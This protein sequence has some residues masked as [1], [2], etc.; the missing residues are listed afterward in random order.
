MD[1][2]IK[3]NFLKFSEGNLENEKGKKNLL[4]SEDLEGKTEEDSKFTLEGD[5]TVGEISIGDE[6]GDETVE[7][8]SIGNEDNINLVIE[9]INNDINNVK[10]DKK[11]IN[12]KSDNENDSAIGNLS[13][14]TENTELTKI[15][16]LKKTN[17]QV[18]LLEKKLILKNKIKSNDTIINK[19]SIN[20][21][22]T[23]NIKFNKDNKIIN[24]NQ[25]LDN[26]K[27]SNILYNNPFSNITETNKSRIKSVFKK[28][29]NYTNKKKFKEN[30][31]LEKLVVSNNLKANIDNIK[32]IKRLE[33]IPLSVSNNFTNIEDASKIDQSNKE[34]NEVNIN[35]IN[36]K[37]EKPISNS[38][39]NLGFNNFD[40]LKNILDIRSSDV[41]ERLAHIFE[42]NINNNR[43]KFEIQLRPEYLGKIQVSLTITGENVDININSDNINTVQSLLE[44]NNNLQKMLQSQGMNLNSFNLN[45]NNNKNKEKEHNALSTKDESN[46]VSKTND[47]NQDSDVKVKSDNLVYI[48]A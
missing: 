6:I 32:I 44:N 15:I 43:N 14:N 45:S 24:N 25:T 1:N 38:S 33:S 40:R 9:E 5:E 36:D 37:G 31:Q 3:F 23:E 20:R 4:A 30:L 11:H 10:L 27:N 26:T 8:T 29:I 35:S 17:D 19:N 39:K 21:N 46:E 12:K 7:K 2:T 34:S 28:Y 47:I 18:G 16:N 13:I 22:E 41:N 42:N 48:K